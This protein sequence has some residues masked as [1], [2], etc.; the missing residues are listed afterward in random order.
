MACHLL[1]THTTA[2]PT[3]RLAPTGTCHFF[4]QQSQILLKLM[5]ALAY[6]HDAQSHVEVSKVKQVIFSRLSSQIP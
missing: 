1:A 2:P 3:T 4:W 6:P 5:M